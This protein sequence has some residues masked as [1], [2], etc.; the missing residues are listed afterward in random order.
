MGHQSIG[1]RLAISALILGTATMVAVF[2]F[3]LVAALGSSKV[4]A[5]HVGGPPDSQ[6]T[7]APF[8]LLDQHMWEAGSADIFDPPIF[9][10]VD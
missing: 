9:T 10:I 7:S 5:D 8:N 4:L 3:L 2:A 6:T 1:S